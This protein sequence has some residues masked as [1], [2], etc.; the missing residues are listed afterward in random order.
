[1]ASEAN[2]DSVS[3][4]NH[5]AVLPSPI[6]GLGVFACRV[7]VPGDEVYS[8][9]KYQT[10]T[11]PCLGSI[12]RSSTHHVLEPRVFRWVNHS[13]AANARVGF[14]GEVVSLI[15]IVPICPGEEICC[16]YRETESTVPVPFVCNCGHC[17][18]VWIGGAP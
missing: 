12:E 1:M 8:S 2:Y 17:S 16:D 7:F 14:R 6:H 13:C 10:Y 5:L 4:A 18:G 11:E 15:A 9:T 3:P